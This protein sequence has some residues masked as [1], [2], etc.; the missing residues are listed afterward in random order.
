M[1]RKA[2][3]LMAPALLEPRALRP[4]VAVSFGALSLIPTLLCS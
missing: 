1:V 4:F 3:P 2:V